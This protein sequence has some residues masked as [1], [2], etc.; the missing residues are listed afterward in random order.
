MGAPGPVAEAPFL[1]LALLFVFL[2]PKYPGT[3]RMPV[4][5]FCPVPKPKASLEA[6]HSFGLRMALA[7][8]ITTCGGIRGLK[9]RFLPAQHILCLVA[10]VCKCPKCWK[11]PACLK[12]HQTTVSHVWPCVKQV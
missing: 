12:G 8:K 11:G 9:V 2:T 1:S 3:P 7:R 10:S 6:E 4:K 5:L